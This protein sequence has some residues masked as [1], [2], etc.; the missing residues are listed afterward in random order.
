M[1]IARIKHDP[2]YPKMLK[3]KAAYKIIKAK[4]KV[5][6]G[7]KGTQMAKADLSGHGPAK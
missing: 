7:R 6:Y 5:K 1:K 2:L 3:Y 4:L